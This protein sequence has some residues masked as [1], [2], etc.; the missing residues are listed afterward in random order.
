MLQAGSGCDLETMVCRLFAFTQA[1][2]VQDAAYNESDQDE[3]AVWVGND[4]QEKR[5]QGRE[6][7]G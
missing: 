3:Q 4:A 1:L 5:Q 2:Q 6:Q 7:Q